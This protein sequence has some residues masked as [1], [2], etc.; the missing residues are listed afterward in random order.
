[1]LALG[2]GLAL[3]Q[4]EF[5][6]DFLIERDFL[7]RSLLRLVFLAQDLVDLELP[8]ELVVLLLDLIDLRDVGHRVSAGPHA[9]HHEKQQKQCRKHNEKVAVRRPLIAPVALTLRFDLLVIEVH[10]RISSSALP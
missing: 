10:A 7:V 3:E 4:R 8:L 9:R 5:A 1:M 6:D 2:P